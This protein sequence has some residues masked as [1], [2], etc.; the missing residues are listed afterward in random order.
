MQKLLKLSAD[1][2]KFNRGSRSKGYQHM[3]H[4][5][6]SYNDHI[7]YDEL[8]LDGKFDNRGQTKTQIPVD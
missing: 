8:K 3:Y 5:D 1:H 6:E 2:Q 7:F 4:R